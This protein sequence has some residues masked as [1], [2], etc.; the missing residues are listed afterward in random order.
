MLCDS[1]QS[2]F[3]RMKQTISSR[4]CVSAAPQLGSRHSRANE[5]WRQ[6]TRGLTTS[7]SRTEAVVKRAIRFETA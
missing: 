2:S 6:R 3:L 5:G 1:I 7:A 4:D